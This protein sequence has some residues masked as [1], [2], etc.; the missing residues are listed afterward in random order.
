MAAEQLGEPPS[1]VGLVRQTVSRHSDGEKCLGGH[2]TCLFIGVK[3]WAATKK[4]PDH[5]LKQNRDLLK[6]LASNRIGFYFRFL[7]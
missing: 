1:M 5:N 3:A 6:E 4:L 2:R 7:R